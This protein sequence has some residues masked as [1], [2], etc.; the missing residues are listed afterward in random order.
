MSIQ[1]NTAEVEDNTSVFQS[2]L[3]LEIKL[4][5][6]RTEL[7][8]LSAR[9]RLLNVPRALPEAGGEDS[10][11]AETGFE[12]NRGAELASASSESRRLRTF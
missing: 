1:D 9:N 7:L 3:P 8:D 12:E 2:S 6:A 11:P 10:A 5:R 4:E